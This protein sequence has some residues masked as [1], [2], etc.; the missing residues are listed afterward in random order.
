MHLTGILLLQLSVPVNFKDIK[1]R[2]ERKTA[3]ILL[4]AYF[5]A[6]ALKQTKIAI[7][8]VVGSH[9]R[10]CIVEGKFFLLQ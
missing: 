1:K 2:K 5:M 8:L 4:G 3:R 7:P 10:Y 9:S 6:M